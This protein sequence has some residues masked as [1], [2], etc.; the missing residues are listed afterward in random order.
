[1]DENVPLEVELKLLADTETL[2][3][4]ER[5]PVIRKLATGRAVTRDLQSIYWD[6]A[7]RKLAAAGLLLRTRRIGRRWVQTLKQERPEER[8]A[9]LERRGEWERPVAGETPEP[10]RLADTPL[11]EVLDGAQVTL[12]PLFRTEFRRTTRKLALP[13]GDQV[14]LALDRGQILGEAGTEP[15]VEAELELKQG[16]P[17]ALYQLARSLVAVLPLKVGRWSKAARGFRLG[18]EAPPPAQWASTP[19]L[20]PAMSAAD[21]FR[22]VARSCL[23]QLHGNEAAL[24]ATDTHGPGDGE[25]VHQMRV[26]LRRLRAAISLFGE[27]VETDETAAIRS[28]ARWLAGE[29]G[30]ARDL[31]VLLGEAVAEV[32]AEL[33]E[34]DGLAVLADDLDS[35]RAEAYHRAVAAVGDHRFTAFLL[36]QG[37]WLEGRRYQASNGALERPVSEFAAEVLQKRHRKLEKAGADLAALDAAGR[38]AL[39]IRV[40]KQRY[41]S[42]FFRNLYPGKRTDNYVSSLARLQDTLGE[43]NDAVTARK[44]L[45]ERVELIERTGGNRAAEIRYAAGLVIG[46]QAHSAARRWHKLAGKWHDARRLKRFWP[47]PGASKEK[48]S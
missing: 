7:D 12:A 10:E 32:R 39:R 26:G 5:H 48:E 35:A 47:K 13:H 17:V 28:E 20:D 46:W 9:G 22:V 40:K 24:L 16:E 36:A 33:A 11:A 19:T 31:D 14:E 38:H 42:E 4:L 2:D 45:G 30:Q 15:I 23:D 34:E 8:A 29:L 41:A 6:T 43:L 18:D 21:A 37:E 44:L 25:A 3:R 1:M 27:A